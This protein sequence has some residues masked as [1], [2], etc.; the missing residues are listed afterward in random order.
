MITLCWF[1]NIKQV[2]TLSSFVKIT[3]MNVF[4]MK[5]DLPLLLRIPLT[6]DEI[7][8]NHLAVIDTFNIP[9]NQHVI[10]LLDSEIAK[11]FLKRYIAVSSKCSTKPLSLIFTLKLL[12]A[13]MAIL[14]QH[15]PEVVSIRCEFSKTLC[16]ELLE[17]IMSQ[18]FSEIDNIET[19]NFSTVHTLYNNSSEKIEI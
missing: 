3:I 15:I 6:K 18:D 14:I 11:K 10:P 9:K 4:E 12:T 8:Q 16:R 13:I 19:Y 2:T 17:N 1:Q 5:W 7:L